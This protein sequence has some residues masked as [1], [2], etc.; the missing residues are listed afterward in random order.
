LGVRLSYLACLLGLIRGSF[1]IPVLEVL[2]HGSLLG[3]P[4]LF[5]HGRHATLDL[6]RG[7][8]HG[9]V[10]IGIAGVV[11]LLEGNGRHF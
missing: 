10:E 2:V 3:G 5:Q 11:L 6:R 1:V 7:P 9:L 8:V 4:V